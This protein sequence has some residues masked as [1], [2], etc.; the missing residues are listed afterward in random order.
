MLSLLT[1]EKTV[2]N[3]K[4]DNVDRLSDYFGACFFFKNWKLGGL[5]K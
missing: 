1:S 2:L 4:N 3:C 5:L